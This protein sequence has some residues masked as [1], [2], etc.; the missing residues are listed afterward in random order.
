[1]CPSHPGNYHQSCDVL[2][3]PGDYEQESETVFKNKEADKEKMPKLA[4]GLLF[5]V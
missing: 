1:M 2:R 4:K 5:S 3:L